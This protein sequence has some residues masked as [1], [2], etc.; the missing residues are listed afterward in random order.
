MA[1]DCLHTN[2]YRS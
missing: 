2:A 1:S